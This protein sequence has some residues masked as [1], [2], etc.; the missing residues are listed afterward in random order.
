LCL[1]WILEVVLRPKQTGKF[2]GQHLAETNALYL[3]DYQKMID[4]TA[5]FTDYTG[6]DA[7]FGKYTVRRQDV[8][9]AFFRLLLSVAGIFPAI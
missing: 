7:K 3:L 5:T 6:L 1:R 9:I 2:V 8:I 4:G